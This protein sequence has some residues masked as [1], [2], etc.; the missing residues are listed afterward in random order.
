VALFHLFVL[1]RPPSA[2][3]FPYTTLFRSGFDRH[4]PVYFVSVAPL[5]PGQSIDLTPIFPQNQ[6]LDTLRVGAFTYHDWD[7]LKLDTVPESMEGQ[8]LLT[9]IRGRAR[10]AHLLNAF[11]NTDHPSSDQPDQLV[12]TLDGDPTSRI[13]VQWRNSADVESGEV[14]YW[15]ENSNDTLRIAADRKVLEDR[16][17]YNDR[18]M[19]RFTARLTDLKPGSRYGYAV[20]NG[21]GQ[22][23]E[24]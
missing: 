24:V 16:L 8:L 4:R 12:L 10:E 17:L 9:T 3:L 6:H 21:Q 11:R 20:R 18:Y 22:Q 7:G 5:K 1:P 2:P 13:V 15:E 19:S 23:S 14:I